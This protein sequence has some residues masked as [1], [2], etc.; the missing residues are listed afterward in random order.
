MPHH[1][2]SAVFS[3][4]DLSDATSLISNLEKR[5]SEHVRA[6]DGPVS[7]LPFPIASRRDP[8]HDPFYL[9]LMHLYINAHEFV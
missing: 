9:S 4:E 2:H 6:N 5:L 7:F 1:V 8:R 3:D